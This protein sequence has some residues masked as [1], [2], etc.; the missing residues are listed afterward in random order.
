LTGKQKDHFEKRL[1][2]I[3][4]WVIPA[5]WT[6]MSY[7]AKLGLDKGT[8]L[9][10]RSNLWED[11]FRA[12]KTFEI[13]KTINNDSEYIL[14]DNS[15]IR[16]KTESRWDHTFLWYINTNYKYLKSN[17]VK[18]IRTWLSQTKKCIKDVRK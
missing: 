11:Y 10:W 5:P 9:K 1:F 4:K 13:A 6:N 7:L 12:T 17:T 18:S 2:W 16:V 14:K 3:K 15:K 8:F